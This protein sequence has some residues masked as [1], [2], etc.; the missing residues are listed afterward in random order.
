MRF[1]TNGDD[2][3]PIK[4]AR[5]TLLGRACAGSMNGGNPG[6][7]KALKPAATIRHVPNLSPVDA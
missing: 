7:A 6:A 3:R 2:L 1:G 5:L 4:E